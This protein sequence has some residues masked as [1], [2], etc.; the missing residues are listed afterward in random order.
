[1][2][3]IFIFS[4]FSL[5]FLA[6]CITPHNKK[7]A[8]PPSVVVTNIIDSSATC[9]ALTKDTKGN[10]VLSW[11][12]TISDSQHVF[13]YAISADEGKTFS[14]TVEIT[15][16][17]NIHPHAENLPKVIFKP[18]GEIIAVWDESNPNPQNAYTALIYY[19]QSFDN[20]KTWSKAKKLVDDPATYDQRYFDIALLPNGE[21]AITW[22][23]NS[24]KTMMD[25]SDLYFAETKGSNGFQDKKVLARAC[26]ECC[27]TAMLTDNNSIHIIYRGIVKDSI[28]DIVHVVS[29]DNG[30]TFTKPKRISKDNWVINGCPHTGPAM[31]KSNNELHFAWYSMG[32]G[33]GIFYCNSSDNGKTFSS[34][35]TVC[36][37]GSAKHAQLAALS[38]NN[39][40]VVWDQPVQKQNKFYSAIAV[41]QRTDNGLPVTTQFLTA[42]SVSGSYPVIKE[43]E[44]N[45]AIV[46]FTQTEEEHS[47]L[48]YKILAFH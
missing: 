24:N 35:D 4:I 33:Q 39:I 48:C 16:S 2:K 20:G 13:C 23:D 17:V 27:R 25:G 7:N 40:A 18:S 14:T 11:I 10:I 5:F 28:R 47:K 42:D 26:C 9:P 45:R 44:N 30:N 34:K 29:T 12:R 41:Q 22:L 21:A 1:M 15:P 46:A 6:S 31:I 38:N 32:K 37:N 36:N 3:P 19:S 8:V 43:L